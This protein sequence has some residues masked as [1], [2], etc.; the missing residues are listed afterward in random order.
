[1]PKDYLNI[2]DMMNQFNISRSTAW[3]WI[4]DS[5]LQTYR[6]IGDRK[7]YVKREDLKRL[8]EPIPIGNIKKA[9]ARTNLAAA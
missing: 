3:K 1:M 8:R 7:S 6:F 4:R 2:E 9:T 5:Q